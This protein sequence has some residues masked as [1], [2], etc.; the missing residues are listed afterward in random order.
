MLP[1]FP[2]EKIKKKFA[3]VEAKKIKLE[4]TRKKSKTEALAKA[5]SLQF[6]M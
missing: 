5:Q 3:A 4:E 6:C 1:E 2:K